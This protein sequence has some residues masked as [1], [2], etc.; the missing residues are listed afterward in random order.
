MSPG[1][2]ERR[3][4][5]RVMGTAVSVAVP[6]GCPSTLLDEVFAWFRRVD[7]TFSVHRSDSQVSR[8]SA[9]ALPPG[10]AHPLVDEVLDRCVELFLGTDGWF[11][12]WPDG[13]EGRV[14]PSGYVKGWSVDV[15]AALLQ[16]AGITDY[17]ISAG[18]DV[19]AAGCGP[20]GGP[21][22]VGV[23]HPFERRAVAAVLHAGDRAVATSG[24]YERG[25]HVWGCGDGNL[26]SA[27]VAGPRLG[28][29]DALATALFAA[30]GQAYP[31][32][33][34]FDGYH[35]LTIGTDHRV[36]WTPGLDPFLASPEPCLGIPAS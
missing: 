3:R 36:R 31:W 35:Y 22:R 19:R 14:D 11:D 26:L 28:L 10:E 1:P 17:C 18:G 33:H 27:T 21:R 30:D 9:R 15:A 7:R 20:H 6:G 25:P 24:A 4:V 5:E 12:A 32:F 23:R 34:R 16:G 2:A 8:V 29:A 13:P